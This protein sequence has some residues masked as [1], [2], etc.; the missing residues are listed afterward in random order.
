MC[1]IKKPLGASAFLTVRRALGYHARMIE[2][3]FFLIGL[4]F[5]ILVYVRSIRPAQVPPLKKAL[6]S[7][8]TFVGITGTIFLFGVLVADKARTLRHP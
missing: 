6:Y 5:S 4:G 7:F 2:S 1:Q 8:F 3:F